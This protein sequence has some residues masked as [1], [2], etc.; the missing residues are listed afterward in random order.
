MNFLHLLSSEAVQH[1]VVHCLNVP[2]WKD[3]KSQQPSK[4][5]VKFKAWNGVY[6]FFKFRFLWF[7]ETDGRW[8]QTHFVFHTQDPHLLPIVNVYNLPTAKSG[9]HYHLEVGP[10]CYL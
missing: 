9:A 1:I 6:A 2:V 5:A 3:E 8:H 7:T 10:V 4:N